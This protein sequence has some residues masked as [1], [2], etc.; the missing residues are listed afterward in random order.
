MRLNKFN[1]PIVNK[2]G[3]III[4]SRDNFIKYGYICRL[5]Y[6]QFR[7]NIYERNIYHTRFGICIWRGMD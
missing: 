3:I 5:E 6:N 7:I 1:I 4:G 2:S